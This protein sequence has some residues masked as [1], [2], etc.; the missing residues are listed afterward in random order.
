MNYSPNVLKH[1]AEQRT[2]LRG[3]QRKESF[4]N[5]DTLICNRGSLLEEESGVEI[6][7]FGY[8]TNEI[9]FQT[10]KKPYKLIKACCP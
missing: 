6:R 9:S 10:I 2:P 7:L 8:K 5:R 3:V 4:I 1:Q